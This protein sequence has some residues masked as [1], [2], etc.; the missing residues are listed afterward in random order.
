MNEMT[1]R[2]FRLVM[3]AVFCLI[4]LASGAV[5]AAS[6]P[7]LVPLVKELKPVVVNISTSQSPTPAADK[8]MPEGFRDSPFE[9]FFS[10]LSR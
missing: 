4:F 7:N 5:Q 9:E 8:E 1:S 2:G 3:F 10:P 6:L